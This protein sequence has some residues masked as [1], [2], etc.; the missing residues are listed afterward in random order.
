LSGPSWRP[1]KRPA[2]RTAER[3]DHGRAAYHLEHFHDL[4]GWSS[5][6]PDHAPAQGDTHQL[7]HSL[8]G[9]LFSGSGEPDWL[10]FTTTQPKTT[11]EVET[12]TVFSVFSTMYLKESLKWNYV[13]GFA[14][15]V[16]AVFVIFK[17]W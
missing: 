2:D 13:V 3:Y 14:M 9:V 5:E 17:K 4:P 15:M 7:D 8:G 1:G 12:L 11:Q 6:V 10:E 16:G